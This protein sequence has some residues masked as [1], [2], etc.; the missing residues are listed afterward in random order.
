MSKSDWDDFL[1]SAISILEEVASGPYDVSS[2]MDF[3]ENSSAVR[4]ELKEFFVDSVSEA[5][6]EPE[7]FQEFLRFLKSRPTKSMLV[8]YMHSLG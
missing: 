1:N 8:Q 2:I 3:F 4:G 6:A 5:D 7:E